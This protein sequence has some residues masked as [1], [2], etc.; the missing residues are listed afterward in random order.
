ML[1]M[2]SAKNLKTQEDISTTF[3]VGTEDGD[4]VYLEKDSD[5]RKQTVPSFS[6]VLPRRNVQWGSGPC[7]DPV[8][9]IGK[10]DE[11]IDIRDLLEKTHEPSK[12]LHQTDN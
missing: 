7:P 9:F 11:N 3:F 10:E 6:P 1:R 12:H 8:F 5:S 2:P 4:L